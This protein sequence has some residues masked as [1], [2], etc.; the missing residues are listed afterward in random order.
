[1]GVPRHPVAAV[2]SGLGLDPEQVHACAE[3]GY[4]SRHHV[5]ARSH[6]PARRELLQALCLGKGAKDIVERIS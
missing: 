6:E 2:G 1:M 3:S 4:S 5:H